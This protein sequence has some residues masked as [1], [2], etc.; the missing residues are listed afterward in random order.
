L[1]FERHRCENFESFERVENMPLEMAIEDTG[2]DVAAVT[3]GTAGTVGAVGA[4]GTTFA[5]G[6]MFAL[7]VPVVDMIWLIFA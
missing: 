3:I 2:M 1:S 4:G 7:G 6:T 5:G